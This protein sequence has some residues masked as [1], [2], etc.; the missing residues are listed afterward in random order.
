MRVTGLFLAGLASSASAT[1]LADI[2]TASYARKNLPS[3]PLSAGILVNDSSV[4]AETFYNVSFTGSAMYPNA[5]ISYCNVTFAYSHHG[6]D[7]KVFLTYWLPSP[8][9]FQNR[10]L[11]TGGGGFAINSGNRSVSGG[12]PYGAV[13][14]LTDGG[15]GGFDKSLDCLPDRQWYG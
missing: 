2:C 9:D 11:T 7:D 5:T 3:L 10:F 15:F 4:T 6:L 14:G 1:S 13:S 8:A 12:I